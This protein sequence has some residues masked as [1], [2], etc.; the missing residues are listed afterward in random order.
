MPRP[1]VAAEKTCERCGKTYQPQ[2]NRQR[3]CSMDCKVPP[4]PCEVCGKVFQPPQHSSGRACSLKCGKALLWQRWGKTPDKPCR[5]CG[6]PISGS[7]K[8]AFCSRPCAWASWRKTRSCEQCGQP[9]Q[10]PRNRFCSK[11]CARLAD[12]RRAWPRRPL[13]DRRVDNNGYVAM[14]TTEGWRSE[15][16]LVMSEAIGRPLTKAEHVHH[17]NGKRDDNR[18]ENLELWGKGHPKGVRATDHHCPGCR[19]CEKAE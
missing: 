11:H 19:C 1:S 16:R 12:E 4:R 3:F 18:I 5:T 13:G 7:Q 10:R 9:T 8:R 14:K 15:H 6:K 17:K 2:S